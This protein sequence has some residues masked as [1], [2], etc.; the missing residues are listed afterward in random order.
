MGRG[1]YNDLD[2]MQRVE[3][4]RGPASAL[5]GSDGIAGAV[6]FTT[7]DPVDMLRGESFTARGR[8]GYSSADE[9]WTEGVSV[10]GSNGALSGLLAYTRRDAQETEN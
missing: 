3:I 7:K 2:L 8:V 4:L 1:G 9:S 6:S 10:A 5:Y